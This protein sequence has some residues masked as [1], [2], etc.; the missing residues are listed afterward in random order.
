M[1]PTASH[2]ENTTVEQPSIQLFQE[3]GWETADCFEESLGPDGSLGRETRA[4][5]LLLRR[6]RSAL[7][8]LNPGVPRQAIELAVEELSR[9]RAVMSL[10]AAN[11]ELY[12]LLKNGVKV[13]VRE[14]DGSESVETV[15]LIDW[16]HPPDNDFFLASQ[17]WIA[18]EMHQRRPDLIGFVNGIPLVFVEFKASHV[19]VERAFHDNLRDYKDT[20]PYLFWYNA[21]IILSNGSQS[22]IGS[23]TSAWEHFNDW[24]KIDSE[25]EKGVISLDTMIRGTCE[26]ERLLDLVEN[27]TLFMEAQ[28]GLVKIIAK[29]HQFLGVNNAIQALQQTRYNQGKLGVFWHTQGSGKSISMVFFAQKVLRKIPGNWTFVVV[30]DRQ[31]LDDQIYKNFSNAGAVTEKQAQARSG[32]QLRRLLSED[33]RYIFTLIQ[34]FNVEK[35]KTYP[36]L[37]ERSDVIVMTDE[38]HRSQYDVFALNMRNALPNAAFIGFTGTPLIASEEKTREVF[39]DYVSIYNFKQSIDDGATVPLYYENR[40]PELQ[41]TNE[42]LN[43]EIE[44]VL[45]EAELD[46]DQERK[47]EREFAREYH[48]ITRDDRLEKIAEDI[49]NHF[50]GRGHQGKAMV[51]CIDKATAV[52]MYDKVRAHWKAYVERLKHELVDCRSVTERDRLSELIRYLEWV[53]MALVVSQSQNEIDDMRQRGLD[54]RPHRLR[55]VNE[56]LDTKFKDK[57][58]PFRIVFVCAMWMTGFDVPSCSTIYLDKPMR[59]H[60]LMQTIARANRVAP[61]KTSGLIVDYV[62]VFRNLR[63]ALAIYGAPQSGSDADMPVRP[64]S[65]LVDQLREALAQTRRFLR[66]KRIDLKTLSAASGYSFIQLRDDALDQILVNDES[67]KQFLALAGAV[68]SLFQ[69]ILPDPAANEFSPARAALQ[70]MVA[71]IR[72]LAPEADI[73]GV[74]SEVNRILDRSIASEG[75]VIREGKARPGSAEHLVDLSRLDFAA[76]QRQF[77]KG[78]K[79]IQAEQL[80]GSVERRLNHMVN[81]N[82]TRLDL[83]ERFQRLID[84]YNDGSMNFEEYLR[85]LMQLTEAMNDEEQ[86]AVSE[87]MSEE[88]LALFDLLT[89][90][91]LKLSKSREVEVKKVARDLLDTLKREK[92]VLDWRKRQQTRA[93]VRLCIEQELDKLPLDLYDIDKYRL[94]CEL[95]YQHVYDS[96][97]DNGGSKYLPAA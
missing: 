35:G 22:K 68:E 25:G 63:K 42:H 12:D 31:E 28:G 86:R 61:G 49:V 27:F 83:L 4:E 62:G 19:P 72:S 20:I 13:T 79:H 17:L 74:M 39:G 89:K 53:D 71:A 50:I 5:V 8:R 32:A 65:E 44:R 73:S 52:R 69:S 10:V 59:N 45:E 30:T 75:Y 91:D 82:H 77:E 88:E 55:M 15:R 92:L 7:E 9:D 37:S 2:S 97:F 46:E 29:N 87:G 81:L 36:T 26:P 48:L 21:L 41:L 40:I 6:L 94:K 58:D 64:K 18:G 11:H 14:P 3:L 76:L 43:D 38:A 96:Y 84:E 1:T 24:K 47:L 60:T 85:Q 16:E 51:I 70:N 23:V 33:H 66:G 56:D 95:A 54:I 80:R 78:R 34:K 93:A 90:P 57:D 67:K